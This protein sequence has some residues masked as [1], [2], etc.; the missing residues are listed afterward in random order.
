M[1][2]DKSQIHVRVTDE[3]KEWLPQLAEAVAREIGTAKVSVS[4]LAVMGL[5]MMKQKYMPAESVEK[6][7]PKK[8]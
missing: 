8:S 5:H 3:I 6:K 1:P 2:S 4:D 7:K